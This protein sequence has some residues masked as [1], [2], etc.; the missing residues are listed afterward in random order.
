MLKPIANQND[1]LYM[2]LMI[3]T[4]IFALISLVLATNAMAHSNQVQVSHHPME[5]A[6]PITPSTQQLNVKTLSPE[7]GLAQTSVLGLIQD[8]QGLIWLGSESGVQTFDGLHLRRLDQLIDGKVDS[9]IKNLRVKQLLEAQDGRILIATIR[10]GLYA[11][12]QQQRTLR[13]FGANG[14][15]TKINSQISF[16]EICQDQ[17]QQIW[18]ATPEGLLKINPLNGNWQVILPNP[19][20]DVVCAGDHIVS[21]QEDVLIKYH[22]SSKQTQRLTFRAGIP[23]HDSVVL[24]ASTDQ[25]ILVGKHN[26]LFR[27]PANFSQPHRVWPTSTDDHI[28]DES[29]LMVNDILLPDNNSSNNSSNNP[30]SNSNSNTA[31]LGT[32][33]LGL[34]LVELST[35]KTLKTIQSITGDKYSLS[36]NQ[37]LRL[38]QDRSQ[39]LWVSVKRVGVDRLSMRPSA[40]TTFYNHGENALPNNDITAINQGPYG[41]LWFGTSRS[42]IKQ[43]DSQTQVSKDFSA[44]IIAAYQQYQPDN[45]PHISALYVDGQQQLWFTTDEGIL[46]LNLNTGQTRF[47][48]AYKNNP[49]GPQVRGRGI[50]LSKERQLYVTDKGAI[51]RYDPQQDAFN[52][53]GFA[54][55]QLPDSKER[56]RAIRQHPDGTIIVLGFNNI[57]RLGKNDLLEP[58]LD[59]TKLKQVFD[60]I[61]GSFDLT[62]Q[63][64]IYIAA[65][66]AL[67]GV[68][69]SQP[70]SPKIS[71]YTDADV[72]NNYF[73]AIELDH[74]D[75]LW[76]STNNGIVYFNPQKQQYH[77]FGLSDGVLVREFNGQ[78]SFKDNSGHIF[79][80]GIN[81]WVKIVPHL[82]RFET[83]SP[84]LILSSYQIGSKAPRQ[85]LPKEGIQMA[86]SDHWLQFSFSAI[87]YSSPNENQYAY[88][89]Q[90]FDPDWRSFG[91]ESTIS[92]TGLPPGQ[93]TL[94]AKAATKRGEWHPQ[95]LIVPITV[96][97]PFYRSSVAFGGYALI[98]ILLIS[99]S[100]LAFA[101]AQRARQLTQ[102]NQRITTLSNINTRISSTLDF[103]L[104][105]RTVY[106][107]IITLMAAD[108][109]FIGLYEANNQ[110]IAFKL[111]IENGEK[112]PEFFVSMDEKNRPAV[113]CVEH[114]KPLIIN[115]FLSEYANYF[116]QSTPPSKP[117]TGNTVDSLMYWPLIVGEQLIGV[118]TVQSHQKHAYNQDQ[119][120][121]LR[122]IASTTA[123]ALDNANAYREIEQMNHEIIN[124]QQQ[125]VQAEKM[126][127]LGTLTAGVAHEINNPTNF[128]HVSAQNLDVDLSRFEQFLFD[129]A[130]EDAD[131]EV[132]DNFHQQFKPLHTHLSTIKSG[133][134]RIKL[135]V[136]DLRAFSQLDA[137]EKTTVKVTGLLQSTVNLVRTKHLEVAEFA[138]DFIDN[139]ILRC[140]PAQLNQVFMNLIVNACDAIESRQQQ[141]DFS[142]LVSISCRLLEASNAPTVEITIKDNGSGMSD[143]TKNKLFEPFYTTKEV[144]K[145]TGLG[146]SISYGIVQQHEGEL[147]VESQLGVGTTF[148][149]RLPVS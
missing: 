124:T 141:D 78:S 24:K 50:L 125:L 113:W 110:R 108:V 90:G 134:E 82:H 116:G 6:L 66:G 16:Y 38:M 133:T 114:K 101:R 119:Q 96:A 44:Q 109:F 93:Y 65:Y 13:Q 15:D 123:I 118:M 122:S 11:Y 2:H 23:S 36:G 63:G 129:L 37:V 54:D 77:H 97:P 91:N 45:L 99:T 138:L 43:I 72:P 47:Y 32:K 34:I 26:G 105:L 76:L 57:Y 22:T 71:R 59:S 139:P 102:S 64:N 52:R 3:S 80:G 60:G 17:R 70:Q 126:A 111:A 9:K 7:N 25:T 10:S 87:D 127:S 144:G 5:A 1:N 51:L 31:W 121:I 35:G 30:N 142:G 55:N 143:E 39:L 41:K 48:P 53:L 18:A 69:I 106:D 104:L 92:F 147:T 19:T 88:F 98:V 58:I 128:V 56:L 28:H 40:M 12:D 21:H 95:P 112:L 42:G 120:N 148:L 68:D 29:M 83:P 146:L 117:M 84:P 73:Y 46:R 62:S 27:I 14:F 100:A 74:D 130:G 115:D 67:I 85:T 61:L 20:F 89:L 94:H 33:N 75:N 107:K 49:Q 149:L 145:G 86:F 135:I 8:S 81:G 140:Y 137:A 136:Q 4:I 103:N 132:L 79:F 131:Q